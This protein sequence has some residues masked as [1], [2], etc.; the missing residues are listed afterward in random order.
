MDDLFGVL[1]GAGGGALELRVLRGTD[2]RTIEV[3]LGASGGSGE[4]A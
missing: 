4:G 2:E 3:V 1:Q